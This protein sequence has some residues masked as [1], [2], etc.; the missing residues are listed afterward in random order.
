MRS[1]RQQRYI[2]IVILAI[3][4]IIS[5]ASVF[6][7]GFISYDDPAY[8][9][10][11]E[12]VRSGLSPST[13]AWAFT[14]TIEANWHPLTWLS[15]E[16]DYSL[17]GLDAQYHHAMNLFIHLL[18]SIMVFLLFESMTGEQWQSAFIACVFA[19]HPL[20]VESVAWIAERK[21]VL[22]GFFWF[23]TMLAY[24][25]YTRSSAKRWYVVALI[26]FMLG[27]MSKPMLV[28]LPFVLLLIDYWPLERLQF[29]KIQTRDKIGFPALPI[30]RIL[31]EKIPFLIF[32]VIS[33]IITFLVQQQ[34]GSMAI[35][36]RLPMDERLTNAV[37]AYCKYIGKIFVP[38]DLAFFYPHPLGSLEL[39][40][41]IGSIGII[42][43]ITFIAWKNFNTEKY[44]VIGWFWFLG[45]LIP[46][47]GIV[48]VGLQSMADRYMYTPIIGIAII[49]A[50]GMPAMSRRI[51]LNKNIPV[52]AFAMTVPLMMW[53]TYTQTTYWKDN[54]TLYEHALKVTSNNHIAHTNLGADL[55]DSGKHTEALV[56]L[57]EALRLWPDE[58]LPH[59]N[60]ARSLVALGERQE[61]LAHYYWI[62]KRKPTDPQ[63]QNRIAD[64]LADE[65]DL[66]GAIE[67]YREA[68]RLD[69]TLLLSRCKIGKLLAQQSKYDEAKAECTFVLHKDPTNSMTH[70]ILGIIAGEL[71]QY[72]EA[73]REFT[74]A[75]RLDSTNADA[76][77][78]LGI[79]YDNLGKE[80]D[81]FQMYQRAVHF[82]DEQWNAQFNLGTLYARRNQ[83]AD[84]AIHLQRAVELF[85]TALG[86][87]ANLARV[88]GIQ[89]NFVAAADQYASI[90]KLD[91]GNA[92]AHYQY[93]NLLAKQNKFR[94]AEVQ[95]REALRLA[96]T[97]RDA[98]IAL[99]K[100]QSIGS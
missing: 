34:G 54:R 63:L 5:F 71:K 88:Y 3:V 64:V 40:Q 99:E 61:A 22:S 78:D 35:S 12:H 93:G 90:V 46:V 26:L 1:Q 53:G 4:T 68:F 95:F 77:N 82:N 79:V 48:Q 87:R 15:H 42:L 86:A 27:L 20:H 83:F 96:P 97:F 36:S 59:G 89:G 62:L 67:H 30:K 37:V 91:P 18:T 47:I 70:D 13:I 60:L 100:T 85:P 10:K 51:K 72:V 65:G 52:A 92:Q 75:I 2:I 16:L 39:W 74:E 33:S 23:A 73:I 31:L 55:A 49:L 44:F 58:I 66:N 6:Q 84:A 28:S 11:N 81:A 76:Y 29:G 19:I 43:L 69:S 80:Q 9:V 94:D 32:S 21:D 7:N 14:A 57:R 25:R 50:W 17:F 98:Q 56:H 45:T 38:T 8:V 24:V 41:I